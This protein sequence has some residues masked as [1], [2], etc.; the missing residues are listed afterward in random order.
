MIKPRRL[1]WAG[2]VARVEEKRNVCRISVVTPEGE[3]LLGKP[4]CRCVDNIKMDLREIVW[5]GRD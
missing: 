1:R 2:H 4:R 5:G 3:R